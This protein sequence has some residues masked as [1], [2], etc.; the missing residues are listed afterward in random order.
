MRKKKYISR[1]YCSTVC[2]YTL[3]TCKTVTLFKETNIFR[4]VF[5]SREWVGR[6]SEKEWC[7]EGSTPQ[8]FTSFK[9]I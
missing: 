9:K 6:K 4:I 3:K 7:T 5:T 8:Y 1:A 2:I